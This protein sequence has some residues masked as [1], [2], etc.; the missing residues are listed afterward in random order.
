LRRP[1]SHGSGAAQQAARRLSPCC[2]TWVVRGS[3]V[4]VG[5]DGGASPQPDPLG[6]LSS[7]NRGGIGWR[8]RCH[9]ALPDRS[10]ARRLRRSHR[11][12]PALASE[13]E[14]RRARVAPAR[15]A[16]AEPTGRTWR[17]ALRLRGAHGPA[18]HRPHRSA[19]AVPTRPRAE[20]R[21][22]RCSAKRTGIR[23]HPRCLP[24]MSRPRW[25][26]VSFRSRRRAFALLRPLDGMF[27]TDCYQ[28]VENT[29]RPLQ[30]SA[31]QGSFERATLRRRPGLR[32]DWVQ[33]EL[34]RPPGIEPELTHRHTG[35][36]A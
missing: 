21:F 35:D 23:R 7:R 10:R 30:P 19:C 6:H 2:T 32:G 1:R 26:R 24:S 14:E 27:S 33:A 25:I 9:T 4:N 16:L 22:T 5:S 12:L 31:R 11:T 18:R 8:L 3:H 34:A 36:E 28:P 17:R 13:R 20:G 15:P 29:R